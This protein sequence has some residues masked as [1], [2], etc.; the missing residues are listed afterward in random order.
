[1]LLEHSRQLFP[2]PFP[3][4]VLLRLCAAH[5]REPRKHLRKTEEPVQDAA[6]LRSQLIQ[7]IQYQ[8]QHA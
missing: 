4:Q 7:L 5:C 1:M 8:D 6:V 2:V 3:V